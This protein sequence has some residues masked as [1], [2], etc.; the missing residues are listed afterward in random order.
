[1][2]DETDDPAAEAERLKAEKEAE[3]ARLK[4]EKEALSGK[5]VTAVCIEKCQHN[6]IVV[7]PGKKVVFPDGIPEGK[8]E[9]F[10][11]VQ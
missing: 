10:R 2:S 3:K 6:G 7:R 5:T 9:F 11:Q 1:M 4:A 8:K